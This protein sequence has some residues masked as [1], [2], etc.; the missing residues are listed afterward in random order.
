MT[1]TLLLFSL[2]LSATLLQTEKPLRQEPKAKASVDFR[3]LTDGAVYAPRSR[4]RISFIVTN[5]GGSPLHLSRNFSICSS[6]VGFVNLAILDGHDQDIRKAYCSGD[7]LPFQD[8]S[9]IQDLRN[10]RFWIEMDPGQIYGEETIIQAPSEP[11]L[12]RL[13]AEI[14]PNSFT[15]HQRQMIVENGLQVL[16]HSR[17]APVVSVSVK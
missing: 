2:C 12:Y 16:E 6:P 15:E 1:K 13:K 17:P 9:L 7:V 14:M 11:G 4:M 10:S 3:V 5:T 8:K